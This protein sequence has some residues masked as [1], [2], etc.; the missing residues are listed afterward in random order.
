[1]KDLK[2]MYNKIIKYENILSKMWKTLIDELNEKLEKNFPN[3]HFVVEEDHIVLYQKQNVDDDILIFNESNAH[4]DKTY[5]DMSEWVNG[6]LNTLDMDM[7]VGS[8]LMIDEEIES[9][10]KKLW[11]ETF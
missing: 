7:E 10:F 1:M 5:I 8:L 6:Y 9:K 4:P 11:K 2:R 3:I